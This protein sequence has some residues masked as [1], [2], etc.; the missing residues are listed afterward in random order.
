MVF[1]GDD[2]TLM[3]MS[4]YYN[5]FVE[6]QKQ[7]QNPKKKRNCWKIIELG[8]KIEYKDVKKENNSFKSLNGIEYNRLNCLFFSISTAFCVF[9]YL[10]AYLFAFLRVFVYALMFGRGF[11]I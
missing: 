6:K 5:R 9:I 8:S 1:L 11:G 10:F 3:M 7:K 4:I 2:I